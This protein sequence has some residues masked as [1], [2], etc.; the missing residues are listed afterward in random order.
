MKKQQGFT[1]IELLIVVAIVGIMLSV[2]LPMSMGMYENYKASIKAQEAVVYIS[3]LRRESFLYSVG[4]VLSSQD[5][6]ITVD[7]Q[8]MTLPDTR[9][10][11]DSPIIFYRNGTTSGGTIKIYIGDQVYVLD[12]SSPLGNLVLTRAGSV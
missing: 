6:V 4:K 8:K 1:L 5:D 10:R 11:I 7:D 9:I 2:S 12:V 3:G